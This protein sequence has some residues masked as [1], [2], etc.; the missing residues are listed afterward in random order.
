MPTILFALAFLAAILEWVAIFKGWRRLEYFAKPGVMIFLL[1]WLLLNG[2]I[3]GPLL[4]FG[5]GVLFSLLGD[6]LLLLSNER[7]DLPGKSFLFGLGAFLLAHVAYVLGFN[8]PAPPFSAVTFGVAF[9]VI[10]S[11]LPLIRRILLGLQQK[12]LRRLLL[13]VRAYAT[14]ISLMLFSAMMTLFRTDWQSSPAYLVSLGALL[15]ISSDVIL[16]WNKFVTPVR[17]GRLLLMVTYHLGQI[18]LVAGAVGQFG[19]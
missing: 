18:A 8:T 11:A 6:V 17:R 19:K 14:V 15:F 5:L 10:V 4:W 9:M 2:A 3:A 13:P 1:A 16:A 12:G 7:R